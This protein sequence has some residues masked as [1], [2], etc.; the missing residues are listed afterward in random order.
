M[1]I[2][3]AKF[4]I[5]LVKQPIITDSQL[6]F[7]AALQTFVRVSVETRAHFVNLAL[8]HFTDRLG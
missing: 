1:E 2:N 8:Q 4:Q 7:R 5:E 3:P 6:E